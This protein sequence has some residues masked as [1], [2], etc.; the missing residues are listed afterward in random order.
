MTCGVLGFQRGCLGRGVRR[1]QNT[2]LRTPSVPFSTLP[3]SI[4]LTVE[5]TAAVPLQ[6]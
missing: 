3:F 4:L 6:L 2:F 5:A 1:G